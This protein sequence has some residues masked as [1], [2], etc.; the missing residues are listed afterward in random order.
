MR[1]LPMPEI[2]KET[3]LGKEFRKMMRD[4]GIYIRTPGEF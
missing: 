4:M 1:Y 2:E 3:P